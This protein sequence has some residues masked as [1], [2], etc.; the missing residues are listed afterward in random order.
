MSA[1]R[2]RSVGSAS[3]TPLVVG[4]VLVADSQTLAIGDL[5]Q[6]N[7]TSRKLEAGVA[8]STTLVGYCN[9]AIT[10]T[11]ATAADNISITLLRKQVIRLAVDQTG[12]KKTFAQTDKYTT[13]YDLKDKGSINPDDITGGMCYVQDFDN[14]NHTVDVI[15]ADANLAIIG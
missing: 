15:F 3:N 12:T 5:V 7:T 4:G 11:T 13:A 1:S 14:T 2:V 10:T 9:Q 8:A 6:V